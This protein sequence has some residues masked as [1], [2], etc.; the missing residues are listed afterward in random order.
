MFECFPLLLLLI[1][2]LLV[3]VFSL[4]SF[5]VNGQILMLTSVT[6]ARTILFAAASVAANDAG[7]RLY[8]PLVPARMSLC[9][10]VCCPW[11]FVQR[12]LPVQFLPEGH[13]NTAWRHRGSGGDGG[14]GIAERWEFGWSVRAALKDWLSSDSWRLDRPAR[15]G[16]PSWQRPQMAE[17]SQRLGR[18]AESFRRVRRRTVFSSCPGGRTTPSNPERAQKERFCRKC[19]RGSGALWETGRKSRKSL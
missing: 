4:C 2:F 12:H 6:S 15:E 9:V 13:T 5:Y 14:E 16:P 19:F 10:F 3:P 7:K 11:G 8:P 17:L 18:Q 1:L